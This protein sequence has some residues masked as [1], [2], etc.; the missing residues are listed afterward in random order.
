MKWLSNLFTVKTSEPDP[1]DSLFDPNW[2]N[3]SEP[4]INWDEFDAALAALIEMEVS[5]F[6]EEHKGETFYGFAL[7]CNAAYCDILFCLNTVDGLRATAVEYLT[8]NPQSSLELE[9]ERLRWSLGDWKYQGFNLDAPEWGKRYTAALPVAGELAI[10]ADINLFLEM[11][12]R[13]LVRATRAGI[14]NKLRLTEDF[15]VTCM[16]H[17][18]DLLEGT[19]RLDHVIAS[20]A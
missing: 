15:K 19:L 14:F 9:M 13:A 3:P 18:E 12:C 10:A 1:Q 6:A 5:R 11:A 2:E 20:L 7:D 8:N 4:Q 16:D 17:D